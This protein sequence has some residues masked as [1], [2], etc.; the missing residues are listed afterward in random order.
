[1]KEEEKDKH[2]KVQLQYL[3]LYF[4]IQ[5]EKAINFII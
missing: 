2:K 1:M 3:I 5:K 4:F